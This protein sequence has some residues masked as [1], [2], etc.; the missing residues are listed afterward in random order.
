M[1]KEIKTPNFVNEHVDFL[2]EQEARRINE[3]LGR[4]IENSRR[5]MKRRKTVITA[6]CIALLAAGSTFALVK[7][8]E[9]TPIHNI[10]REAEIH[11]DHGITPDGKSVISTLDHGCVIQDKNLAD[12][13]RE[14]GF[15][16]VQVRRMMEVYNMLKENEI[17]IEKFEETMENIA[18]K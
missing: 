8:Q 2:Q 9:K 16:E 14:N 3:N 6:S 5:K 15:N 18:K 17:G 7:S 11:T 4:K 10:I 13:A 12:Y 1:E